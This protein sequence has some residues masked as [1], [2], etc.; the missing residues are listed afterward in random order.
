L[1]LPRLWLRKEMAAQFGGNQ[2]IDEN[3]LPAELFRDQATQRVS[4]SL[5]INQYID[6]HKIKVEE[7]KIRDLVTELAAS[8]EDPAEVIEYIM[9]DK[10]QYAQFQA[11][12]LEE[13]VIDS[14]LEKLQ[15]KEVQVSYQDAI[16]PEQP[17]ATE[18]D[19]GN[20]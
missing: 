11:L 10:G 12:A 4:T 8:Y 16:K 14:L 18:A 6:E 5:I 2:K 3:M 7:D 9:G 19:S 17:E 1:R 13:Q 20:E 15:V